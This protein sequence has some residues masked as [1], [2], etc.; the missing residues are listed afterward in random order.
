VSTAFWLWLGIALVSV[1]THNTFEQR[2]WKL[3]LINVANILVTMV[4][5]AV[6]IGLMPPNKVD[7]PLYDDCGA[8][9]NCSEIQ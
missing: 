6:I 7:V 4:V 8:D 9:S 3:T 2:P 1:L 5:M